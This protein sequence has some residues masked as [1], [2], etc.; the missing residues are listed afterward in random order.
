[1]GG[2][3]P[4]P[5]PTPT[6][7]PAPSGGGGAVASKKGKITSKFVNVRSGPGTNFAKV[8]ELTQGTIVDVYE[9]INNF[10][11]LG[12]QQYASADYIQI[13]A[14]NGAPAAG[15]RQGKVTSTFLNVRNGPG[16]DKPKVGELKQGALVT[17][18][19]TS[20]NGWHRIGDARWVIGS[21]VKEV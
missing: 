13:I 7:T 16:T 21:N 2:Q 17:I 5:T 11:H 4:T 6:P 10:Y 15:S 12:N 19:E 8:K 3:V 1:G 18:F 20:S 9:K 14:T